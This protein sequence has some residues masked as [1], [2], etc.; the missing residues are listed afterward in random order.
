M[1]KSDGTPE[2]TAHLRRRA[3]ARLST[4]EPEVVFPRAGEE[5]PR[6]VHELQVHQVELEM[7]N[8]ELRLARDTVETALE[9]YTDLYDFAPVG[10]CTLARDTGIRAANL[11]GAGLLGLDRSRLIGRRFMLY[12]A[13]ENRV[14]F[15]KF[16]DKVFAGKT[17]QTSE[18]ML[19]NEGQL[20]FFV[21]IEALVCRSKDA[22]RVVIIDSSERKRAEDALAEKRRELEELNRTLET[23]I[24]QAVDELRKKDQMLILQDRRAL[25]GEMI[26][27]IAHQWRQPLNSLGLYIQELTLVY[28]T[29]E[30]SEDFLNK[31][32]HEAMMLILHMSQTIDDFRGFFRSDKEMLTF[33]VNQVIGQTVSLIEKSFLNQRTRIA[34]TTEGSPLI[35]GYPNE[36]SQ[37]LL[38]ILMNARDELVERDVDDARISIF[39]FEEGGKTI[40]TIS[41]NAG[42]VA[43][44]IMDR[45]FE[46]YFSTKGPDKGTGVG[47]FMS[48]TI[49]EKNMG[50]K[51]TF[52]NTG[53]GAEFRIE[54]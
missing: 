33:G 1:K 46:P 40:V 42:G 14:A 7:Q 50:G 43:E 30:F 36:Y 3:E 51:L 54:V 31:N 6:L 18:V 35:T 16:L 52:R 15:A 24:L 25:M 21:Q 32:S 20:P 12:V 45:L 27:N 11:A 13:E 49:I 53:K 39:S 28:D 48:K 4:T 8:E 17:K 23:R 22:C 38:N 2:E 47:L 41:D 26:N 37:V 5:T 10:Y 34:V 19:V 9:M 29:G 44:E